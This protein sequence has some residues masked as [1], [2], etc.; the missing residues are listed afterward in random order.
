MAAEL[1]WNPRERIITLT[2]SGTYTLDEFQGVNEGLGEICARDDFE[3]GYL[4]VDPS[5]VQRPS[6][7]PLDGLKHTNHFREH[8]I[9]LMVVYGLNR[10]YQFLGRTFQVVIENA[11]G[12]PLVFVVTREEALR[13]V[14][15]REGQVG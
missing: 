6:F 7:S 5:T 4:L 10:T 3:Y 12:M 1:R 9:R 2:L 14:A 11:L 15:Q 8:D 13:V